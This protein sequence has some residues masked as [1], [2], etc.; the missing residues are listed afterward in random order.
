MDARQLAMTMLEYEEAQRCADELRAQIESAVLE[1]G[2]TQQVGNV[3]ATYRTG[4][5]NYDYAAAAAE[6]PDTLIE[7]YT[8]VK[9]TVDWRKLALEG[10]GIEK[11]R[12][13]FTQSDPSVSVKIVG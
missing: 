10:L 2:E 9:T 7:E 6:V 3:K 8:K 1:I 13:P 12:L 4:R 5:K 11:D